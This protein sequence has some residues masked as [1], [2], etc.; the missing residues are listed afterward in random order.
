MSRHDP[1]DSTSVAAVAFAGCALLIALTGC[2]QLTD[3]VE[4]R[5][6]E[7]FDTY[8]QAADGWVGVEMPSWIPDDATHLHNVAT[9][10][11]SQS[12]IRVTSDSELPDVCSPAERSGM[13]ALTVD[14]A[15]TEDWTVEDW[16]DE[17]ALCGDYEVVPYE[18]GWI[19]W[20][21]ATAPGQTPS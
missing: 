6:E 1:Y 19:G 21:R 15:P 7:R 12:L 16:P 9:T 2:A 18:D 20:F 10:D 8:A 3:L 17:V 13:P 5:H 14:W 4:K 11:E